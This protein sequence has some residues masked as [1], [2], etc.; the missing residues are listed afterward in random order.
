MPQPPAR[1]RRSRTPVWAAAALGSLLVLALTVPLFLWFSGFSCSD[2]RTRPGAGG[3]H[4]DAAPAPGPG[5]PFLAPGAWAVGDDAR[6]VGGFEDTV[7]LVSD[8]GPTVRA[9]DDGGLLWWVDTGVRAATAAQAGATVLIAA[10]D[11]LAGFDARTGD[12][13]WCVRGF[14]DPVT[15]PGAG[16]RL[17]ARADDAWH[18]L[19]AADGTV[20]AVPGPDAD[21]HVLLSE[22]RVSVWDDTGFTGYDAAGG[23]RLH[24]VAVEGVR[25]LAHVEE[26]TV[27][28]LD[29]ELVAFDAEGERSWRAPD[30][31][32]GGCDVHGAVRGFEGLFLAVAD[33]EGEPTPVAL[34]RTHAAEVWRDGPEVDLC[35][36]GQGVVGDRLFLST[37]SVVAADGPVAHPEPDEVDLRLEFAPNGVL[38]GM[39]PTRTF[40]PAPEEG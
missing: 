9:A 19:D 37:G 3:G 4:H 28:D 1:A 18:L 24:E 21:A 30:F 14:T 17:L 40:H 34:T 33:P 12:R 13:S 2:V 39:G 22:G 11:V 29:G 31:G 32:L 16:D 5:H 38:S 23:E 35:G 20:I 26:V 15:D 6:L 27:L 7:T 36:V 25:D 10:G 8:H